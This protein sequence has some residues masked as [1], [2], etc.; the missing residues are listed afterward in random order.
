[1]DIINFFK[2]EG[3]KNWTELVFAFL[4]PDPQMRE[5]D[6]GRYSFAA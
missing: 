1:M 5:I 6:Y 3:A 4:S 2:R